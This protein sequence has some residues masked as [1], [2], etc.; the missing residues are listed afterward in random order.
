M[1][2]KKRILIV[3]DEQINLE[4]FDVMLSKLGFEV[5]KAE[6][7]LEALEVIR[8][9]RPD[10]IIL[11]NVMPRL[12]GWEVTRMLKTESEY[13]DYADIP[14]IMFSAMDDVKDKIE[15]L[16]LGA[17]DYITKPFNFAEVLARIRAVLRT[18]ELIH[19]IER[20]DSR[21]D[22][23]EDLADLALDFV[24][25]FRESLEKVVAD[26]DLRAP[27]ESL[28][29]VLEDARRGLAKLDELDARASSLRAEAESLKRGETSISAIR[30][31]VK[32]HVAQ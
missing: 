2:A 7:G 4:F 23:S 22:I 1:D 25:G 5:R 17:D 6:D 19:Q 14:I 10:L 30:K 3:D 16:E 13:A 18:H 8:K 12:S 24:A 29:K 15:G 11:D 20:R 26:A 28:A 32:E 27:A 21:L 9:H 31:R